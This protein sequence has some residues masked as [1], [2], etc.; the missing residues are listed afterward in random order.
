MRLKVLEVTTAKNEDLGALSSLPMVFFVTSTRQGIV[1]VA[2]FINICSKK[3]AE[4][5]T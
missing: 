2:K 5:P 3:D 1:V 4:R